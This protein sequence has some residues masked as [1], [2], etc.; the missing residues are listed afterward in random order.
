[1]KAIAV[2]MVCAGLALGACAQPTEEDN[3]QLK[4]CQTAVTIADSAFYMTGEFNNA[5]KS[6]DYTKADDIIEQ[7][8]GARED[9][10]IAKKACL[11]YPVE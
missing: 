6:G 3:K 8:T 10:L 7:L 1:M 4:A 5:V 11:K 2:I 9:Y